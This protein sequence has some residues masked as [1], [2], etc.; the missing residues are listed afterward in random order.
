M[1]KSLTKNLFL[2][3]RLAKFVG[4]AS[5]LLSAVALFGVAPNTLNL[6]GPLEL[7]KGDHVVLLGNT[8]AERMQHHGWLETYAQLAMADKE[9]V[10][11]NHGFRCAPS[12]EAK[13]FFN[14]PTII[15]TFVPK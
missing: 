13:Q 1:N 11:R 10:F 5:A 14:A 15:R 7:N 9:L 4:V 12:K 8:L 6:N 2:Q 3:P